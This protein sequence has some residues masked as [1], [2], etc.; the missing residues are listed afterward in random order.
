M[1]QSGKCLS[2]KHEV[3]SVPRT[4]VKVQ[5]P[6]VQQ[7]ELE[8]PSAEEAET[9]GSLANQPPGLLANLLSQ[10]VSSRFRERVGARVKSSCFQSDRAQSPALT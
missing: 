6:E 1:V 8:I 5:Q 10:P 9:A 3:S 4:R 7:P 2:H